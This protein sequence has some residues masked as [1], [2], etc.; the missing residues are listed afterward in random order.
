MKGMLKGLARK[1]FAKYG[2]LDG[3][4]AKSRFTRIYLGGRFR[5]G[6]SKSGAGSN[7]QETEVVRREL[8]ALVQRLGVKTFLD[9]PCGDWYWMRTVRLSVDHYIGIDI[10]EELIEQ[11]TAAYSGQ[12]IKF[13]CLDLATDPLP[14]ADLIFSRDC[15]VHLKYSDALSVLKNFR[16]SGA[17]YL[18]T[19]SFSDKKANLELA[20]TASFWRPLNLELPPFNFPPPLLYLN[21]NCREENGKYSDKCLGLWTLQDITHLA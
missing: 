15:L 7:L 2:P 8:P 17:T 6:E 19:T 3:L 12:G 18:L 11:N 9:A 16:R 5:G 20:G 13:R 1:L 10:V 14:K 21:E 4:E